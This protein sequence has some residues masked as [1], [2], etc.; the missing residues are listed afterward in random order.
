MNPSYTATGDIT[1]FKHYALNPEE[2]FFYTFDR[3]ALLRYLIEEKVKSRCLRFF[4]VD[5]AGAYYYCKL[6]DSLIDDI[7]EGRK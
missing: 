4:C 5:T 1:P 7:R 2:N 3:E 6:P